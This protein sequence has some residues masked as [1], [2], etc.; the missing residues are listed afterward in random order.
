MAKING[1]YLNDIEDML[2]EE[3]REQ[4]HA[5]KASYNAH[6]ALQQ[7]FEGLLALEL[8]IP[9]EKLVCSYRFGKL[10]ISVGEAKAKPVAVKPKVS[11][12]DWLA[13]QR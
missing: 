4:Y 12:A 10:S 5:V 8:D 1:K 6:K 11:L 3:L 7:A 2:S 9:A 13:Q